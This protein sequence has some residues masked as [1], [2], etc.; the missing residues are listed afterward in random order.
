MSASNSWTVAGTLGKDPEIKWFDSGSCRTV[1]RLAV[2]RPRKNGEEQQPIWLDAVIWGKTAEMV[3]EKFSKG[4]GIL[5]YGEFDLETWNDKETGEEKSKPVIQ[6]RD[7]SFLPGR[8]APAG[9]PV[10]ASV[11]AG[12]GK[13]RPVSNNAPDLDDMPF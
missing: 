2:R 11:T 13:G 5:V 3:S 8:K 6:V 12:R 7:V 10:G 9:E 4:D 1:L